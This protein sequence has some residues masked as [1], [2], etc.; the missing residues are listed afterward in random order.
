[1]FQTYDF[2]STVEAAEQ[3]RDQILNIIKLKNPQGREMYE[4]QQQ[5]RRGP[6]KKRR[7]I[8]NIIGAGMG[9]SGSSAKS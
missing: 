8:F 7:S 2:E 6:P 3:F 4:E 9:N 1:M 5:S